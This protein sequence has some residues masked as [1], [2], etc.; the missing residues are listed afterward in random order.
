MQTEPISFGI[1]LGSNLGDRLANLQHGAREVLRRTGGKLVAVAPVYETAPVDCP[2]ESQAFLNTVIEL[3]ADMEPHAL[4]QILLA[5]EQ[6][7]GR[8]AEHERNAPRSLDLDILYAD[9]LTVNDEVL[10]IPHPRLH[11]RRF[12]LQPLADIRPRLCLPMLA[13]DAV[14]LLG[15]LTDDPASTRRFA[16]PAWLP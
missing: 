4:H 8:P 7:L 15:Q 6:L 16:G 14:S 10:T 13:Y 12:V 2:P 11:E 3:T 9:A 1:A 5:V